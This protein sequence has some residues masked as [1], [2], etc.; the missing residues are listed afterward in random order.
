MLCSVRPL[1]GEILS[2]I[3]WRMVLCTAIWQ[4]HSASFCF[5]YN[6]ICAI[7][8]MQGPVGRVGDVFFN[9][10]K[11]CLIL[12]VCELEV[13]FYVVHVVVIVL[14]SAWHRLMERRIYSP[15]FGIKTDFRFF[16]CICVS[17]ANKRM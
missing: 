9:R 3:C 15:C 4:A 13:L 6:P 17:K 5:L 16:V 11:N 8:L 12:L 14:D 2:Q 7:E 1:I 10:I